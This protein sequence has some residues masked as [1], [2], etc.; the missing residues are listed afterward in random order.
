[1]VN[2]RFDDVGGSSRLV[3]PQPVPRINSAVA[4]ERVQPADSGWIVAGRNL[5][6]VGAFAGRRVRS[7][8]W[9]ALGLLGLPLMNLLSSP[10]GKG[11][12][13]ERRYIF[14]NEYQNYVDPDE[15]TTF[16]SQA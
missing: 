3:P 8:V 16:G 4:G 9:A 14:G 6:A 13:W 2:I 7:F 5:V 12:W 1:M 15:E 10:D 11:L